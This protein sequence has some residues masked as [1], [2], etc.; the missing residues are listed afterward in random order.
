MNWQ[1]KGVVISV[2]SILIASFFLSF[3][4]VPTANAIKDTS[5]DLMQND[6]FWQFA[7]KNYQPSDYNRNANSAGGGSS[8]SKT[9]S[10]ESKPTTDNNQ[11][12][13]DEYEESL[14]KI[15]DNYQEIE[16]EIKKLEKIKKEFE[17]KD[18][19]TFVQ[20]DKIEDLQ[21][22]LVQMEKTVEDLT[23]VQRKKSASFYSV[24][25]TSNLAVLFLIFI[26]AKGVKS[27]EKKYY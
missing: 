21:Q 9:V 24:L 23:K 13:T 11:Q 22:E 15:K 7:D 27:K 14:D 4:S 1:K 3:Y 2:M 6:D 16:I 17:A 20:E 19:V 12:I 5:E 18:E 25:V 10:S 8:S 26:F